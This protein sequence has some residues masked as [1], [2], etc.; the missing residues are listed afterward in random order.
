MVPGPLVGVKVAFGVEAFG[1][2]VPV[3]PPVTIDHVPVS[4]PAGELPP[5]PAVVLPSQIVCGPPLVDVGAG[6]SVILTS[7]VAAVHGAFETVQRK[8]NGEVVPVE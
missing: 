2:K 5:S 6:S 1:L 3:A 8:V 7:A 4:P